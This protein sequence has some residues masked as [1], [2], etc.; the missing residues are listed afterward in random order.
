MDLK[1]ARYF[2]FGSLAALFQLALL[3]LFHEGFNA[4][5]NAS[6][7]VSLWMAIILNYFMQRNF[8]FESNVRHRTALPAF[9]V[10]SIAASIINLLVFDF[11]NRSMHYLIA[12]GIAILTVFSVN[13]LISSR[14]LFRPQT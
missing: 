5:A 11:M 4:P 9:F 2:A 8:T 13:Y 14:L 1:F 7:L 10:M 6:S 3:A 12:Q